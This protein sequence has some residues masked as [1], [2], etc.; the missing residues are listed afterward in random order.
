MKVGFCLNDSHHIEPNIGPKVAVYS[1]ATG[2]EFCRQHQPET[3]T[4]FE[5]ISA[6]WFDYY[7]SYLAFQWVDA[8][9]VLPGKYWLREDVNT[10]R[11]IK[12]VPGAK[13]PAYAAS[14]TTIPGFNARAQ[15]TSTRPGRAT[16]VTLSSR[17][18][19]DSATPTYTV[20]SQPRHGTL[21]AV[22]NNHVTYTPAAG[23]SG[24]D[25]F[26]V[27]AADPNSPFPR[28]PSVATVSIEVTAR[29]RCDQHSGGSSRRQRHRR[30]RAQARH[31]CQQRRQTTR[32]RGKS[33]S[34]VDHLLPAAAPS[35]GKP[36]VMIEGAPASI[37][38]GTTVQLGALV[39][40]DG[41]GVAWRASAGEITPG[42]RYAAPSRP[43]NGSVVIDA[44][45]RKGASD[46]RTITIEPV[47]VNQPAPAAPIRAASKPQ[48]LNAALVSRVGSSSFTAP[49]LSAPEAVLVAGKLVMST[50]VTEAGR[51]S[52]S[53]QLGGKTLGRCAVQTPGDRGF[54]CQ[55]KL[56]GVTP[57]APIL[58][59]ASLRTDA[60]IEHSQRPVGPVL[61]FEMSSPDRRQTSAPGPF[62][63]QFV[64]GL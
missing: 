5:G 50:T 19:N 39:V 4:L 47:Q 25:S 61:P 45:S 46:R 48:P 9:D 32:K 60:R 28:H 12:E 6:G 14:P 42:G 18:W 30:Q 52:L 37:T 49:A 1:D 29:Q 41:P 17:A 57:Y 54:T 31:L 8:S 10:T 36:A 56:G 13:A 23:Y 20:V 38:A 21:S 62:W 2:R 34:V 64:C 16:T 7:A 63:S 55:L 58:V 35:G 24:I 44:I 51:V 53:A 59:S 33:A 40:N 27:S 3:T 15:S 26:S 22:N 43:P 11:V